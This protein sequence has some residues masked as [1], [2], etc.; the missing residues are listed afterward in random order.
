MMIQKDSKIGEVVAQNFHTA[1][2]F[3]KHG[4]DFCCGGKK[5]IFEAC[6]E[7]GI[8]SENLITEIQRADESDSSHMHFDRWEIDFLVDYIIN[9]HHSYVTTAIPTIEHHLQKVISA[10]A[11][12][13]SEVVIIAAIFDGLKEEL[14]AHLQKEEKMLFPYIRKMFIAS[15]NDF[16]L[17]Y[18]P[19][20]T[21][22]NPVQVMEHEH[23]NAGKAMVNIRRL[24]N[25]YTPPSDACSTFR[26]L[27]NE[28]KEFEDDLHTHVHLENNIL[29]PKAVELEKEIQT[30]QKEQQ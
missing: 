1:L 18:P 2:I 30:R 28:L 16:E 15:K 7:K 21:V 26:V 22:E 17:S 14:L 6:E 20:G 23:E 10:H 8:E 4:L 5:S 11:E 29:F 12:K 13:H 27:Y 24:S 9:N 19:F 3:E 25:D